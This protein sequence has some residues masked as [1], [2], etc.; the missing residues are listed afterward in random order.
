MINKVCIRLLFWSFVTITVLLVAGCG[1]EYDRVYKR[2]REHAGQIKVIDTHEHQR[3]PETYG[4]YSFGFYHLV[5]ASYLAADIRT[6]GGTGVSFRLADSL[7]PDQ[8]WETYGRAL[9]NSQAT[10]YYGHFLRG[11]RKLYGF[12][13]LFFTNENVKV[14]SSQIEEN[15]RDYD[16]WFREAFRKSG[17]D[18]MFKDQHWDPFNTEI[19][20]EYFALVFNINLL[21]SEAGKKPGQTDSLRS[22]YR[23]AAGEGFKIAGLDDYLSY[24]DHLFRLN[25]EKGAVA[26][27]NSQAYSRTLNYEE[28]SYE[29]AKSLY[30]KPS[31]SLSPEEVKK[32][33]DFL[34]QWIIEEAVRYDLP[35]Q[36]HTGY[37]AGNGNSLE[38]GRPVKLN[39]LFLKYPDAR[40]DLFHGGYPWTDEFVALGKM[41]PNVYLNLVWLP[42][43]SREKAV[44]TLGT[45]LDCVPYNKILWGGDCH[46]IEESAGS[47][48]YALDVV[49]EVLAERVCRGLLNEERALNILDGIFRENARALFKL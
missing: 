11:F 31:A 33:E 2:L 9:D 19:D 30:D 12:S 7:G 22:V 42:Q 40:F 23:R 1:D 20:T 14:L 36:I 46:L 10:S 32:I 21:V 47:L 8:L 38:N 49:S 41:F 44:S 28:V 25:I 26:V 5:A 17:F 16:A 6:A 13:D 15:Y 34:F 43:I 39:N 4:E 24:C 35:V 27:K 29:E 18:L 37:L 45:M 48:D 3:L